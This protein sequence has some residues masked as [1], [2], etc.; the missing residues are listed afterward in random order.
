MRRLEAF[1][2]G[3]LCVRDEVNVQTSN[4]MVASNSSGCFKYSYIDIRM[5]L[6]SVIEILIEIKLRKHFVVLS[7]LAYYFSLTTCKQLTTYDNRIF[8]VCII[9]PFLWPSVFV[10]RSS[11]KI[12][13]LSEFNKAEF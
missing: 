6:H 11:G 10:W 1:L 3:R 2:D 12:N 7:S 8:Y 13:K 5:T 4:S 9:S